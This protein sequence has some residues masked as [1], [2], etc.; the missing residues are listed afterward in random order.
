MFSHGGL[1]IRVVEE[2]DLDKVRGLRNE[3]STWMML[4]TVGAIDAQSQ[5]AWFDVVSKSVSCRYY[6]VCDADH[7]FIGMVRTDEIDQPNRSMRVGADIVP[8]L[9]G[10]GYGTRLYGL[11]KKYCF[12]F[13]NMHRI[14]L[15]VMEDNGPARA[16]Y[17]RAGFHVEG[18]FREAV[19][20]DGR[21]RDYILMSLLESE[22]RRET[23]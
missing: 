1:T 22:Y 23:A 3:P 10:L 18:R 6:V 17:A 12:D 21:Y 11:L 8:T 15:L 16:L 19:F 14:W 9:R 20:R 2:R 4:T 5:R 13:L 7:D